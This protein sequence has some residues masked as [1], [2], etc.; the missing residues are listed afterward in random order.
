[1]ILKRK[2]GVRLVETPQAYFVEITKGE[3]K[4]QAYRFSG[5]EEAENK[6]KTI[7]VKD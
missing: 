5:I 4:G 7:H 2:N 6:Y 3:E 1:M